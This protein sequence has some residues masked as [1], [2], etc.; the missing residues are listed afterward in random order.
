MNMLWPIDWA[1]QGEG[2]FFGCVELHVTNELD[3]S[4]FF[5]QI[6]VTNIPIESQYTVN[7]LTTYSKKCR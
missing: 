1:W 2:V 7:G 5:F 3:F 4:H 6:I